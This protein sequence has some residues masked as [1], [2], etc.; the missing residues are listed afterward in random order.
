MEDNFALGAAI[1]IP[2]IK[3]LDVCDPDVA[4]T[5]DNSRAGDE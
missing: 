4:K 1:G 5:E 2:A 3:V